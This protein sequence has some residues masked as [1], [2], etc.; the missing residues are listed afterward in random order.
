MTQPAPQPPAP[1]PG[2][3]SPN[4][5]D[6]TLPQ[7]GGRLDRPVLVR[8]PHPGGMPG[9]RE[10]AQ[11]VADQIGLDMNDP[12]VIQWSRATVAAANLTG[13]RGMPNPT[14]IVDVLRRAIKQIVAFVKDPLG[15]ELVIATR[16][17]L[18]LS[19]YCV[20]AGDCDDQLVALGS[21]TMSLGIPIRLRVRQYR[22]QAQCHITMEFDSNPRLGGPWICVD[23]S[24][25]SGQC[26]PTAF[27]Q[28][29]T[30]DVNPNGG[31]LT[32]IGLGQVPG[33][34]L[35]VG[36]LGDPPAGAT[37][38][39]DDQAAAWGTQL[40]IAR[41]SLD[42]SRTN[43]R[44]LRDAYVAVRTDLG[45]AAVDPP[46][47]E[48]FA[49]SDLAQYAQGGVWSAAAQ[50][51]ES[52]LLATADFLSS[53]MTQ[54]LAGT[55]QLYWNAGDLFVESIAGDPYRVLM[56]TPAGASAPVPT[57]FDA[58]GQ[59]QGTIGILPIILGAAALAVV[60]I[61]AAYAVGKY[62]DY[63]AQRHHD[64]ALSD[65]SNN[66]VALVASGKETPE[67]AQSQ[68]AAMSDLAKA[69]AP[70][71]AAASSFWTA[72]TTAVASIV[73]LV[74]LGVAG[75]KVAEWLK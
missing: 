70:P 63:L 69:S 8:R 66:Q 67:Q 10:S 40:Q 20:R 56:S 16:H 25:D 19:G 59:P 14:A 17:L 73:G 58:N 9:V 74:V 39:P 36:L 24:T 52:Q 32:F 33:D 42:V 7:G 50:T 15:T 53:A 57:Y 44:A 26:S 55:R 11:A 23:P 1:R 75:V 37:M 21:C 12:D 29:F 72:P 61:A 5:Q 27:V 64:D 13:P 68:L 49:G 65:V 38:M 46:P 3:P 62:C 30:I 18:C 22:G 54:A 4:Y 47:G 48:S 31:Q 60:S 45:M 35:D 51:A 34:D 43:L 41:D 2:W 6:V 28:E 71:A